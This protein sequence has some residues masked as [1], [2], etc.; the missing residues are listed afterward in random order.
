[1]TLLPDESAEDLIAG[2]ING[3]WFAWH[4]IIGQYGRLVIHTAMSTGLS[5]SDATDAAQLTWLRFW[6]H[7]HQIREPDRLA[8]WLAST[9]RRE[10]IRLATRSSRYVLCADPS[11]EYGRAHQTAVID[12]YP[13]D[14]EFDWIVEQ[15]LGRLP[16]RYRTLLR[17]LSSEFELSYSEI[18]DVLGLPIG[19]IGPMRMRA[20]QML[21]KTPEMT[22]GSFPQPALTRIA[23]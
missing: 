22:S 10:A 18:A 12:V 4:R 6:E 11:T 8:A 17:L 20:I 23:S 1:M 9:A 5:Y 16:A 7:G 19:S 14:Q 21:K 2:A 13:D 3:E 15:A